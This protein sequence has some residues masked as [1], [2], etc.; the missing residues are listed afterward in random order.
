M[1]NMCLCADLVLTIQSPFTPA[2]NRAKWYYIISTVVTLLTI[3]AIIYYDDLYDKNDTCDSCL[4]NY[5]QQSASFT[6]ANM[7]S[8]VGN[9][10]LAFMLSIYILVAIYSFVFAYRKLERPGVSKEVR[11]MFLKKHLYYVVVFTI[12]WTIQLSSNYFTL[13]N[14]S[15]TP[16]AGQYWAD[17]VSNMLSGSETN[18]L[19]WLGKSLSFLS[20]IMTFST[21][22]FLTAV[23]MVEPLFRYL[24]WYYLY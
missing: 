3:I 13:F 17:F 12:I 15:T 19:K 22:L 1:L 24:L 11:S 9:L 4:K 23:R 21:G 5:E 14:P 18:D 7:T 8:T 20:A 16:P 6:L 2:A 10:I